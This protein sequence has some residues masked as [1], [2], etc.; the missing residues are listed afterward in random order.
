M[1]LLTRH[2][3]RDGPLTTTR[4]EVQILARERFPSQWSTFNVKQSNAIRTLVHHGSHNGG[5]NDSHE[6]ITCDGYEACAQRGLHT[7]EWS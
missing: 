6:I 1:G 4:I 2:S 7:E 3:S 5:T